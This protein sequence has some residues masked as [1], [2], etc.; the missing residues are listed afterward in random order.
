MSDLVAIPFEENKFAGDSEFYISTEDCVPYTEEDTFNSL[1]AKFNAQRF[2][3][4]QGDD[5][6]AEMDCAE[7]VVGFWVITKEN[8]KIAEMAFPDGGCRSDGHT[9][10]CNSSAKNIV[11]RLA[12]KEILP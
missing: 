3:G 5:L 11:N 8:L 10:A 7:P 2:G 4:L 12:V 1:S 9:Y 6:E